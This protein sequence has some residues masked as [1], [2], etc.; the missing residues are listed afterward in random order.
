MTCQ[1]SHSLFTLILLKIYNFSYAIQLEYVAYTHDSY[2][3]EWFPAVWL[4]SGEGRT[5]DK[6]L[7]LVFILYLLFITPIQRVCIIL[8]KMNAFVRSIGLF[9][10]LTFIVQFNRTCRH[11]NRCE[12]GYR[13]F[14][15]HPCQPHRHPYFL[16][17]WTLL[18]QTLCR[19]PSDIAFLTVSFILSFCSSGRGENRAVRT[20]SGLCQENTFLTDSEFIQM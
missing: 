6:S 13:H 18:C 16:F 11:C 10:W 4:C 19:R 15:F 5:G 12:S 9:R 14:L 2:L 8:K 3:S 17:G 7:R 20:S 1:I